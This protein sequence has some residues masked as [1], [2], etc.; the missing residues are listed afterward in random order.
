[1]NCWRCDG[2]M[3]ADDLVDMEDGANLWQRGVRCV[4]CGEVLDR[5]IPRRRIPQHPK[6]LHSIEMAIG[7]PRKR[8]EPIKVAAR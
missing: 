5:R 8:G 3:V 7:K 6:L 2:L 1:M 4:I